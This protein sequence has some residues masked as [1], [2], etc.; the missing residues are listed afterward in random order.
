LQINITFLE[1]S[2]QRALDAVGHFPKALLETSGCWSG[3]QGKEPGLCNYEDL[4]DTL[5]TDVEG[6]V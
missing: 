6:V 2:F 5:F 3:R 4:V 1:G